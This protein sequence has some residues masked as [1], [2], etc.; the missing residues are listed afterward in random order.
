[1]PVIG[2]AKVRRFGAFFWLSWTESR[3]L[4]KDLRGTKEIRR[5]LL[6]KVGIAFITLIRNEYKAAR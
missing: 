1:M 4:I 5:C 6:S 2:I 3:I